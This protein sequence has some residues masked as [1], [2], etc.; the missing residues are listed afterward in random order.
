MA[1]TS[2]PPTV[3]VVGVMVVGGGGAGVSSSGVCVAENDETRFPPMYTCLRGMQQKKKEMWKYVKN[4]MLYTKQ[5]FSVP[6]LG[7]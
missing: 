3:D 4:D 6:L 7:F 5:I 1:T 2:T